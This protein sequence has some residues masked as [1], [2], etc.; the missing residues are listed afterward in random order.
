MDL[1]TDLYMDRIYAQIYPWI[2]SNIVVP[3]QH[4]AT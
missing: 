1:S 3:N 2:Y 4:F